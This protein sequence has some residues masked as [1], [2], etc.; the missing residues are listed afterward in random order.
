MSFIAELWRY[1]R[2]RKKFWMLP[3]II[4]LLIFG[5]LL[6][7]AQG[8]AVAEQGRPSSRKVIENCMTNRDSSGQQDYGAAGGPSCIA[9][10]RSRRPETHGRIP[11]QRTRISAATRRSKDLPI[12]RSDW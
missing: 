3:I 10:T 4:V 5:G 12:A 1:L 7:L 6:V 11:S 2:V 9:P 8:S